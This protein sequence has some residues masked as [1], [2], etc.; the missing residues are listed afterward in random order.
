MERA[1]M[2]IRREFEQKKMR[3]IL[4]KTT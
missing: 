2:L 1:T 4:E 3:P